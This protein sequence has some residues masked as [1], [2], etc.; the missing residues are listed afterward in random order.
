[1]SASPLQ[2]YLITEMGS[3]C[4]APHDFNFDKARVLGPRG[5][6]GG[7]GLGSRGTFFPVSIVFR[8]LGSRYC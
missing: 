2:H 6:P 3:K 1:M 5:S 8:N 4:R 7:W